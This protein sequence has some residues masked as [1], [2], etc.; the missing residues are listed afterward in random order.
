VSALARLIRLFRPLDTS[1]A[2]AAIA[3]LETST[4]AVHVRARALRMDIG[5]GDPGEISEQIRMLTGNLVHRGGRVLREVF[6]T[7]TREPLPAELQDL[8]DRLA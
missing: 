4:K 1:E 3:R 8:L 7:P 6:A 5:C 2:E